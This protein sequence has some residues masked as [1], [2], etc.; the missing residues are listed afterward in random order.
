M[1]VALSPRVMRPVACVSNL[2]VTALTGNR[3]LNAS[4]VAVGNRK[5]AH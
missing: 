5:R 1:Q 3:L 4:V 2:L